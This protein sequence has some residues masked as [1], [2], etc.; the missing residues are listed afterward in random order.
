VIAV[1][2]VHGSVHSLIRNL[3]QM[4]RQGWLSP[5]F[6]VQPGMH[7]VFLGDYVDY[8]PYGLEALWLLLMLHFL[9]P[10]R[11]TL[12]GGNHEDVG[13]NTVRSGVPDNFMVE[14]QKRA[15]H[16]KWGAWSRTHLQRLYSSM[17][18]ALII[19]ARNK[20]N[21]QFSHGCGSPLLQSDDKKNDGTQIVWADVHQ[22]AHTTPS[23]RGAGILNYGS[24]EL[25]N[26][27]QCTTVE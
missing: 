8:G 17:P 21:L 15:P 16:L 20:Y 14:I 22:H 13:Q 26:I 24:A 25:A 3:L 4:Q 9:N 11:V 12:L 5:S 7:L 27:L 19:H 2:D 1:G 6:Q 23:R 10:T 18:R